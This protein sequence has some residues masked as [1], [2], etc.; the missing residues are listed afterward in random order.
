[1]RPIIK[2]N[3]PLDVDGITPILYS[4]YDVAKDDLFENLGEYCSF[5][6]SY[7]MSSSIA[8][9][10]IQPKKFKENGVEI[11]A[12]LEEDWNNFLLGCVHCNSIKGDK[13]VI[14]NDLHLPHL[15]NTLLSFKYTRGGAIS[16]NTALSADEQLKAVLLMK[17]VGL[18]RRPGVKD[19]SSKD[20][21]W[22]IRKRAWDL[23]ERY[24]KK[25]ID[26]NI[27]DPEI[28]TD[29]ALERGFWS[30]WMQVFEN[31]PE[32]RASLISRFKGTFADCLVSDVNRNL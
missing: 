1:M 3:W 27:N 11:Y 16:V 20:K 22:S 23:A 13:N 32:V 7:S 25:Y 15:T 14:L 21:R 19:Y 2:N 26:G 31:Y 18:D 17:L 4:P 28:I 24:L 30:V 5:C 9:E 10:H 29:F 8:V 6:E 12:H